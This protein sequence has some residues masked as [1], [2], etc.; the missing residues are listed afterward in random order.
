MGP[1]DLTLHEDE[2]DE[3]RF[4]WDNDMRGEK[5]TYDGRGFEKI[6]ADERDHHIL[7]EDVADGSRY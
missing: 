1:D 7:D 2:Y 4:I 5:E 3:D 6:V